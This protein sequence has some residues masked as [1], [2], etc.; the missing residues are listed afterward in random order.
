MEMEVKKME[1]EILFEPI[2]ASIESRRE[3]EEKITSNIMRVLEGCTISEAID[4]LDATKRRL[5][6]IVI[7]SEEI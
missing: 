1:H 7:R 5:N 4:Y 2:K 6:Q 3:K